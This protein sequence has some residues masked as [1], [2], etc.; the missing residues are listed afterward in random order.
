MKAEPQAEHRW[1]DQLIGEWVGEG[2]AETQPGGDALKWQAT[3]TVRSLGG[4]WILLE[5]TSDTPDGGK[6]QTVMTLGYDP[7]KKR[8]TG[9]FIGS[10]MTHLWVYEGELDESRKV[11]TLNTVGPGMTPGG[12][13]AEYRD[14]VEIKSPDHRT[15][16][17]FALVNGEWQQVMGCSYRRR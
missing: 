13:D 12:G 11:L 1:L 8:F 4:V 17:S 2:D 5:S 9:T 7:Q 6:A 16:T 15:L 3:E 14:I 10:M